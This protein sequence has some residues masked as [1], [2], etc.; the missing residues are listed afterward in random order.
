MKTLIPLATVLLLAA[1]TAPPN[2]D[3]PLQAQAPAPLGTPSPPSARQNIIGSRHS[4]YARQPNEVNHALWGGAVGAGVGNAIGHDAES[5][6][7][8]AAAGILGGYYGG[9]Y[10]W[11]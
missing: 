11:R 3:V 10:L 5:T 8:G 4:N 7:Y 6:V 1:C 2:N 9:S